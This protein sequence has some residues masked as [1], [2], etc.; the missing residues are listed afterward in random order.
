MNVYTYTYSHIIFSHKKKGILPV[1]TPWMDLE[2]IMLREISQTEKDK[3]CIIS[4]VR[5]ISKHQT[6]RNRECDGAAREREVGEAG[7]SWSKANVQL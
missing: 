6:H 1:A 5:G 7:K 4:L 2:D 3:Y